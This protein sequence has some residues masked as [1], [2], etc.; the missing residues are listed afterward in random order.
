MTQSTARPPTTPLESLVWVLVEGVPRH[1]SD[2]AA[3]APRMRPEA[4]CPNCTQPLT[5]K[6]GKVLRHHAAHRPNAECA[7]VHPETALHLN[8]KLALAQALRA[9]AAPNAVLTFRV[10]CVGTAGDDC[11]RVATTAWADGWDDVRVEHRLSDARR[12]DIVLLRQG[13]EVGALEIVVSHAMAEEKSRA[14]AGAQIPWVEIDA[15]ETRTRTDDWKL[16]APIDARRA[17]EVRPWRCAVHE[18]MFSMQ[19][20]VRRVRE[21]AHESPNATLRS[22]RVVDLYRPSGLRE[23]VIYRVHAVDDESAILRLSRGGLAIA[24][25]PAEASQGEHSGPQILQLAFRDDVARLRGDDGTFADSPMR[26]AGVEAA[27][28]IVQEAVFDRRLPD[29]TVLATTYPRR[30]FFSPASGRWFLPP[31]MRDVRWDRDADDVF[32]PHPAWLAMT[33][34][35][36]R[37]PAPEGSW[38]TL[39]FAR[40]PSVAAFGRSV[41]AVEIVRGLSRLDVPVDARPGRCRAVVVI[42]REIDEA[43]IAATMQEATI[44]NDALWISHP[45]DWC[46]P[47]ASAAWLPGGTDPRGRGAV[48]LDGVGVFR[49]PAI[50]REIASDDARLSV[51][52]VR[53]RMATRVARLAARH[54]STSTQ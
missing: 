43:V 52:S 19:R 15:D 33:A 42:E 8:C 48:V 32:A 18:G 21:T 24:S 30:W 35:Q 37:H 23:R 50:L 26:W 38:T 25:T 9:H 39:I 53:E 5:L 51:S 4:L 6:L 7:A 54:R 17:G 16:D 31:E 13:R 22:A 3:L 11:D 46:P 28:F 20:E 36:S 1:I 2:F 14:L 40:R 47:L 49:A 45:R 27:E 12:P 29:P 44:P 34:R 10:R 41:N